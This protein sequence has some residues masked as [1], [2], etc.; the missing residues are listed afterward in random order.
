[1][2]AAKPALR[3]TPG[4]RAAAES[5]RGEVRQG[6]HPVPLSGEGE[7]RPITVQ[8]G[9]HDARSDRMCPFVHVGDAVRDTRWD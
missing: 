6:H 5:R 4:D 7:N 8:N 9:T 3:D 1:M 2:K